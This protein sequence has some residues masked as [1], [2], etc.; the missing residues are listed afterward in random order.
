MEKECSTE[1]PVIQYFKT[2]AYVVKYGT[3]YQI[4]TNVISGSGRVAVSKSFSMGNEKIVYTVM[5]QAGFK[6]ESLRVYTVSG[7]EIEVV[8]NTFEMPNEDVI[9]DVSF[10][11]LL[12]P[13]TSM[14]ISEVIFCLAIVGAASC[15]VLVKNRKSN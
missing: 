7:R 14:Y 12:N 4:K 3:G 1:V 2:K 13:T 6:I 15:L 5:P 9:T 10:K 11:E 8:D